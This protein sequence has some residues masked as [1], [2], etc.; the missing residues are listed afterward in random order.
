MTE[1]ERMP[2][3]PSGPGRPGHSRRLVVLAL[4]VAAGVLL[5]L[6]SFAVWVNR[7]AL[8]TSRFVDTSSELLEDDSIRTAVATRAVDELYANV[9]VQAELKRQLPKDFKPAS[10]VVAALGREGAYYLANRALE[11]PALQR[12]WRATLERSH[13][14]LVAVLEG[15][16][17]TVSTQE[18][19]VTLDLRPIVLDT[20]GRIGIR[21]TVEEE[22]PPEAARVEVLRSDELDAAQTGF[23][24][25]KALAWFLPVFTVLVFGLALFL[26]GGR[27]RQTL[28]NSGLAVAA[29]GVVALIALRLTGS[30]VVDSLT[31]DPQTRT[32]ADDAWRVVTQLLRSSLYWQI[33]V[34]LLVVL[35]A[36]LAGP[37]RYAMASRRLV[38]PLLRERLYPYAALALV[39]VT[40]LV[41]GPVGDFARFL[42]VAVIV[43]LLVWGLELLRAETLREFPEGTPGISLADVRTRIAEWTAERRVA[44]PAASAMPAPGPD[45]TTQLRTLAELH[46]SDAL[47]D[48]EYSAAKARVLRGE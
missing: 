44:R 17:T 37:H 24:L 39:A 2:P 4:V 40:L 46:A 12:V 5:L 47:T 32:A 25:L 8:N 36:W 19:V 16:G 15:G 26:A 31:T 41:S 9:D 28:R 23:E 30:Y 18:G 14:E 6:T 22:L 7:V 34:G 27:R 1:P 3:A 29:S 33:V 43:A 48:E 21:Q 20:A 35:G 42:Y 13:A 45:L 38:A 11:Q 10:G